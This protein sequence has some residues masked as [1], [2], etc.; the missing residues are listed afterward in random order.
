MPPRRIATAHDIEP[1]ALS[2]AMTGDREKTAA[3]LADTLEFLGGITDSAVK[4]IVYKLEKNGKWGFVKE[5]RPPIDSLDLMDELQKEW[6]PGEYPIRVMAGSRIMTTKSIS[7]AGSKLDRT[8][9]P[10]QDN[11]MGGSDIIRLMMDQSARSRDDQGDMFKMMIAM[12]QTSSQQTMQAMQHSSTQMLALVTAMLGQ[13]ESPTAMLSQLADIN[14]KM[15]GGNKAP[16]I[17]ETVETLRVLKDFASP[18]EAEPKDFF[19]KA[20]GMLPM[21]MEGA[22]KL[23]PAGLAGTG[24]G[25]PQ[26]M[27]TSPPSPLI[28]HA[29]SMVENIDQPEQANEIMPTNRVLALIKDDV[30]FYFK[31]QADPEFAAEGIVNTLVKH[32]VTQDELSGLIVQ[33]QSSPNF[34]NDLAAQGIDVRSNAVWVNVT[35]GC[36]VQ[37]YSERLAEND[38]TGRES[39]SETDITGHGA[40]S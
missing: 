14:S 12:M 36:I 24:P 27:V 28:H 17:M 10:R 13:K 4:A 29:P 34:L 7:I 19:D 18:G 1:D 16:T 22:S 11:G 2:E 35:L 33:F 40:P 26:T 37:E 23:M 9:A 38:D 21:L 3:E 15:G 30:L 8:G 25:Q 20:M 39:R 6:G 5:L 31:K 32:G